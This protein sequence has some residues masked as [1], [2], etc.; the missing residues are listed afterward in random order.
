MIDFEKRV[1][2][3]VACRDKIASM[4]KEHD[5]KVKPY[6]QALE[7]LRGELLGHLNTINADSVNSKAGTVYKSQKKS[8]TIAD[9][10]AFRSFIIEHGLYDLVDWRANAPQVEKYMN[11]NKELP[12]GVNYSS[13]FVVGVRRGDK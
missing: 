9:P 12:P 3:F 7:M 5:A 10:G 8:A 1:M 2:Q 11:D 6:K 13:V 4:D